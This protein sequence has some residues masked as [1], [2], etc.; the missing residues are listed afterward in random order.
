MSESGDLP[1]ARE[2]NRYGL[3]ALK[4][5]RRPDAAEALFDKVAMRV[6]GSLRADCNEAI[7]NF[8][9]HVGSGG[10]AWSEDVPRL[11]G[12]GG[13]NG[14]RWEARA[15]GGNTLT[16]TV[17]LYQD[18]ASA[19]INIKLA[20]NPIRT[21]EHLLQ[22][23]T[24]AEILQTSPSEFFRE[25]SEPAAISRT[26]DRRDNMVSD[27][28]RFAGST[29]AGMVQQVATYLHDFEEALKVRLLHELAPA[30]HGFEW[31]ENDG[32]LIARSDTVELRLD[33][34]KLA[35][36]HCEVCWERHYADA[37][38]VMGRLADAALATARGAQIQTHPDL[39]GASIGRDLAALTVTIPLVPK[40]DVVLVMYAK[41]ADRLR[42][43]VRYRR[44]ISRH[45]R[46]RLPPKRRLI[47]WLGV[48]SEDAA[49]RLPWD[50]LAR[51]LEPPEAS[52]VDV[53]LD[54]IDAV[55]SATERVPDLRRGLVLALMQ[56]GAITQTDVD[57]YAPARIVERLVRAGVLE[58]VRLMARDQELGRR[59]RLTRRYSGLGSAGTHS[60]RRDCV[61]AAAIGCQST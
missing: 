54:L 61:W 27:F 7:R 41:A 34:R 23:Y 40:G 53:L 56:H 33:W 18:G 42:F 37:L 2:R 10:T 43:E 24:P 36:T 32:Q 9:T 20:L 44:S 58:H 35:V 48:F 16:G 26:L 30:A 45:I 6:Q 31:S 29:Q 49:A 8:A 46:E 13:W 50:A 57:G 52:N 25:V 39:A 1:P 4:S 17:E 28:L 14:R 38:G 12:S 51:M 60:P 5:D 55:T 15:V 19:A 21:L 3:R 11:F 22:R 47:D 59:Y